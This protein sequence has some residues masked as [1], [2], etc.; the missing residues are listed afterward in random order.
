MRQLDSIW[1]HTLEISVS[2]VYTFRHILGGCSGRPAFPLG[3]GGHTRNRVRVRVRVTLTSRIR[4]ASSRSHGFVFPSYCFIFPHI[5]PIFLHSSFIFPHIS[6]YFLIF[7]EALGPPPLYRGFE[8]WKNSDLSPSLFFT[9][10]II[11]LEFSFIFLHI[12]YIFLDFYR[13][14]GFSS[15]PFYRGFGT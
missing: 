2:F 11:F 6:P 7:P 9:Y 13:G 8:T 10:S 4:G 15:P 12:F 3:T 1:L 5:S 14:F